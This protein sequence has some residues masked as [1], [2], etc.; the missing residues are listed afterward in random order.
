M[1]KNQP[2]LGV[3]A[4]PSK[5]VD[6]IDE[7]SLTAST[8]CAS[9]SASPE[10]TEQQRRLSSLLINI[11]DDGSSDLFILI[12]GRPT[13]MSSHGWTPEFRQ[14]MADHFY[15]SAT[16]TP[17]GNSFAKETIMTAW[18]SNLN[19][20]DAAKRG[21]NG[22]SAVIAAALV[23]LAAIV[24]CLIRTPNHPAVQEDLAG[25]AGP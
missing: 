8:S 15:G 1:S 16:V 6:T 18:S 13:G 7:V 11:G 24:L 3:T 12:Q 4:A 23:L 22:N 10:K 9:N 19:V 25:I 21:T 20:G 5:A 14:K 17:E 2:T